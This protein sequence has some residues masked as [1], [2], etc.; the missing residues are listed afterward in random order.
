MTAS[1]A[2]PDRPRILVTR[3]L[4]DSVEAALLARF[5][6]TFNRGDTPLS[7][8][9]L[10]DALS[11][12]DILCP[13]IT[14]PIDDRLFAGLGEIRTRLIANFGAGV[15]HIDLA[16]A[17]ALGI[18]V[19]NTPSALTDATADL[20]LMLILMAARRAGEGE[21]ELR[22]GGW[23]GWRP[24]HMLGTDIRGLTLGLF[25]YGRIA[26]AV[27]ERVAPLGMKVLYFRRSG[28]DGSETRGMAQRV[29]TVDALLGASDIVSLHAPA[30]P[31]THHIIDAAALRRMK[32][33]AVLVNTA[34]G[35]LIDEEALVAALMDGTI[36]GA[37]LDVY[38]HEPAIHPA[39]LTMENV[40]LM[41]HLGSATRQ[42]REGMGMRM[43]ANIE[44]F[45][46]GAEPEDLVR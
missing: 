21:R 17:R 4:P 7:P 20:T 11:H 37:A 41:P 16:A 2:F 14:D 30:S 27:A 8:A 32:P 5:D 9:Q 28:P 22:A 40:V 12:Y 6:A 46:A 34:R 36:A 45:C 38:E 26:Q 33:G 44:A 43:L 24:T 23:T 42:T 18:A 1:L 19:T 10:R 39:L 31:E 3:R 35:T 25:G 13:T 29:D 15:N